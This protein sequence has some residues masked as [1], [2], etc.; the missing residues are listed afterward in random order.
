M[1]EKKSEDE[2]YDMTKKL[3]FVVNVD[4]FFLS[5]RLILADAARKAG[6]EVCI[7]CAD[8]G[9]GKDIERLGYQFHPLDLSR[10]G[11]NPF[12]EVRV[13]YQ[14]LR[15]YRNYQPD[16]V[17]HVTI[18]PVLYGTMVSRLFPSMAVVNAVSGLG[19]TFTGGNVLLRKAIHGF[20]KAVFAGSSV[21]VIFQNNDD[22]SLFV[23]S[24]IV[25]LE[26]CCLIRGSGVNIETF[27]YSPE[28]SNDPPIVLLASR[29][30][31]DKGIYEF[32]EAASILKQ[33]GVDAR[34]VLAGGTDAS[35]P[36]GIP[37]KVLNDWT[38]SG[39]IEWLGHRTDMPELLRIA[40]IVCLPSYREGLP[41]VLLE[42]AATGRAIVATD[43]PG[44]RE[45][46][47]DGFNGLLVPPK[48]SS[49][50]AEAI[51][52]LIRAPEDRKCMGR[53]GREMVVSEFADFH[54]VERT[55]A[56]YNSLV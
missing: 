6:F 34:F 8:T 30:L 44:C 38:E 25:N 41:K 42:A 33:N 46:V 51:E 24:S 56:I 10:S 47:I 16:I 53:N 52:C 19:Y 4:W 18:K 48:S 35:N 11:R 45:V 13:L 32:V 7:A 1:R 36:A 9:Y 43:V 17:H 3:L 37:D 50:L 40:N 21:K 20:Y 39:K 55:L 27:C 15:L 29:M 22:M 26:Q 28:I 2:M 5:H 49:E 14:L 12:R 54:V 31:C 23:D